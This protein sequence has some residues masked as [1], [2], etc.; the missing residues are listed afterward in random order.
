MNDLERDLTTLFLER[1][2]SIDALPLAPD[3]VLRRGHRRQL[4]TVIGG[5][6]V[7]LASIAALVFVV[8]ALRPAPS[9]LPV[10]PSEPARTATIH[11]ISV[12][13]PEG[14]TLVDDWPL[15]S[16]LPVSS[17]TCSF[18][19]TGIAVVPSPGGTSPSSQVTSESST[20]CTTEATPLPAGVPVLQLAN[21]G[22]PLDASVCRVDPLR[23]VEVPTDGVAVYV[24]AFPDGVRTSDFLNA[25]PGGA[26]VTTFADRREHVAY[27]A[28]SVIG[29]GASPGDVAT[30]DRF[31]SSLDG[32]RV[33]DDQPTTASPGYV[34][35]AGVDGGTTWRLEAGFPFRGSG[36][37]IG[38]TLIATNADGH[39]TVSAPVPPADP[40]GA[41]I[42]R[43]E[44][45]VDGSGWLIWGAS[46]PLARTITSVASDGTQTDATLVS[47]PEGMRAT[48]GATEQPQ[49]DGS[50]WFA[51]V[52]EPGQLRVNAPSS[53]SSTSAPLAATALDYHVTTDTVIANGNDLG[54][55]W[56]IRVQNDTLTLSLDG[57]PPQ[58]SY[59]IAGKGAGG[60]IDVTGG[61]FLFSHEPPSVDALTV[62][63]D[64]SG[65][66]SVA[67]GRWMPAGTDVA[68]GGRVWLAALPGD[69]SGYEHVDGVFPMALS[70]STSPIPAAGQVLSAGSGDSIS[71][72]LRWSGAGCPVIDVVYSTEEGNTGTGDCLIPW[73]G[74][75][76]FVGGFYG[77][78]D[79]VVIVTGPADM[80]CSVDDA[81]GR[82][83]GGL[84]GGTVAPVGRWAHTG[85]CIL[86]IPVGD[87][88]TVHLTD[89]AGHP[90]LGQLG[91]VAITADRGS[92]TIG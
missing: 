25:C 22:F 36:S 64:V 3:E 61:T 91:V 14:W 56:E 70:W 67:V 75:D 7:A 57:E 1:A 33:P 42:E 80:L 17:Q 81:T 89:Q 13:A 90:I 40:D 6:A 86:T 39:E 62:S 52:P 60:Q 77:R 20:S 32:L 53:V 83:P 18:S 82:V 74:T 19:A 50:I 66:E 88:V 68:T 29:A 51:V 15:A 11:G 10:A 43:T 84:S 72:A 37:G 26:T 2:E 27:A 44:R 65:K 30:V 59:T 49:L 23:R 28:V 79:A 21:F 85:S 92:L 41:P 76:P 78:T 38:A 31:M 47:W 48:T 63:T 9:R 55:D 12:T 87:R 8:G 5:S 46:S 45:L 58:G 54:H 16:V 73:D 69:G 24:A 71:W 35:A 4:R 34:V